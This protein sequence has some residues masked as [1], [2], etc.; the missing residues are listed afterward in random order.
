MKSPQ[1]NQTRRKKSRIP[2]AFATLVVVGAGSWLAMHPSTLD[3]SRSN[4]LVRD[5]NTQNVQ[6][7]AATPNDAPASAY[8][9]AAAELKAASERIAADRARL[10]SE[11]NAATSS[12]ATQIQAIEKDRDA[13]VDAI[14]SELEK[15]NA[16]VGSFQ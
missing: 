12:A 2:V 8:D 6:S 14:Q 5:Q 10:L 7:T 9:L 11:L 1:T 4:A 13:K 3:Y 16:L 15:L